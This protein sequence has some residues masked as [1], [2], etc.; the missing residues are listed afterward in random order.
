MIKLTKAQAKN[1]DRI[2]AWLNEIPFKENSRDKH[3]SVPTLT[4]A[5]VFEQYVPMYVQEHAAYMTPP[6]MAETLIEFAQA[7]KAH[8]ESAYSVLEPCAGIGNL[9]AP[10][11]RYGFIITAYELDQERY[12]IGSRLFPHET[13]YQDSPFEHYDKLHSRFDL[14]VMNPPFNIK[15]ATS[16]ALEVC[17]SGAKKI[18]H[19]FLE[20]AVHALRPNGQ[21]LMIAPATYFETLPKKDA[22]LWVMGRGEWMD[23]GTLPGAFQFTKITVHGWLYTRNDQYHNRPDITPSRPRTAPSVEESPAPVLAPVTIPLHAVVLDI[24]VY[25]PLGTLDAGEYLSS[26]TKT[27]KRLA[28]LG[29][30]SAAS[31]VKHYPVEYGKGFYNGFVCAT[32]D[33]LPVLNLCDRI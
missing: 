23:L 6:I 1:R 13:W 17:K 7:Q 29:E 19:L 28:E 8:I 32:D 11:D 22:N 15:W 2:D 30:R 25:A 31:W 16:Q 26:P 20:L 10:I 21:A 33:R 4:R 14:V 3:P 18:E 5:E 27:A 12:Q 9:I 24:E